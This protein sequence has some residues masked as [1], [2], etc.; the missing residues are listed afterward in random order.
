MKVMRNTRG[1][2][3][4]ELL[5]VMGII[6]ILAVMTAPE[7]LVMQN[8]AKFRDDTQKFQDLLGEARSN[9][10]SNKTY[11]VEDVINSK[12]LTDDLR[13]LDCSRPCTGSRVARTRRSA[14]RSRSAG[15]DLGAGSR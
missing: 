5:V 13:L 8:R 4:I 7:F 12:K 6:A 11:T 1:F 14:C 3:L 15:A 10:L 2:T 9:A